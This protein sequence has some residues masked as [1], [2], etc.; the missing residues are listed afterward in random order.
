MRLVDHERFAFASQLAVLR[1]CPDVLAKLLRSGGSLLLAAKILVISRL[2]HKKGSQRPKPPPYLESIRVRLAGFRRKLLAKVDKV[3]QSLEVTGE[4]LIEAMCA[5][6]LATSSSPTDVLRHFHHIR[7]DAMASQIQSNTDIRQALFRALQIYVTT[8]KETK[9][10]FPKQLAHALQMLK[11]TPTI[12]SQELYKLIE[13]NL[14]LYEQWIGDDIKIFVPYIRHDELQRPEA[15]RILKQWAKQAFS[16]FLS[17]LKAGLQPIIDPIPVIQLRKDILQLWLSTPEQNIVI[18]SYE[19]LEGL[20]DVFN[21]QSIQLIQ[22]QIMSL[23][24]VGAVIDS[25]LLNWGS[26]S[27]DHCPSLWDSSTLSNEVS[28]GNTFTK[29]LARS[30]GETE[31]LQRVSR[32][33]KVWFER[34]NQIQEMIKTMRQ[35]RWEDVIN[36]I[37]NDDLLEDK[38][39]VL[40]E[41]DPRLLQKELQVSLEIS[42]EQFESSIRMQVAKHD[43]LH[44]SQKSVFLLRVWREI[45]QNLPSS[46]RNLDI[47]IEVISNLQLVVAQLTIKAPLRACKRRISSSTQNGLNLWTSLWEGDPK[48]PIIPSSWVFRLLHDIVSSMKKIGSDIWSAKAVNILKNQLRAELVAYLRA[49]KSPAPTTPQVDGNLVGDSD[50]PRP[51]LEVNSDT[52]EKPA[53]NGESQ[54]LDASHNDGNV[55]RYFDLLYLIHATMQKGEHVDQEADDLVRFKDVIEEELVQEEGSRKRMRR[56]AEEYWRRTS[57]LFALMT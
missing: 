39:E 9:E 45:R 44:R 56:D 46:Y 17:A 10:Y 22:S 11:S 19:A 34:I 26:G 47:G 35:T 51:D 3:L 53:I 31:A 38:Q 8:M 24:K 55:Q 20:R 15:D 7:L 43:E 1:N 42:L 2:L 54:G 28:N 30:K 18:D 40:S 52:I 37:D 25:T 23:R 12:K 29:L 13:L 5:F 16:S 21:S 33:Y 32:D 50:D 48:L 57:M 4:V 6:S 36:D 41:D 14:D 49:P 27:V